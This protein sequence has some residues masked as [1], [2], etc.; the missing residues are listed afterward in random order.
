[1]NYPSEIVYENGLL[2]LACRGDNYF[3]VFEEK[4]EGSSIILSEKFRFKV[5]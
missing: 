4:N 2:Y 1:M 5:G 3:I